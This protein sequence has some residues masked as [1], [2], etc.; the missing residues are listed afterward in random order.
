MFTLP[1]ALIVAPGALGGCSD[2]TYIAT[3][4]LPSAGAGG[5]SSGG[6]T[7]SGGMPGSGGSGAL[8]GAAGM[9]GAA[10]DGGNPGTGGSSGVCTPGQ[11]QDTGSCGQCGTKRQTCDANGQWGPEQ[12]EGQG[13]CTPGGEDLGACSDPCEAKACESNCT[14]SACKLKAGAKCSYK[15]G[16]N[17][18]C[19]GTKKWQFCSSSSCDWFPCAD[20]A[21]CSC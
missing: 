1:L 10:G 17:F 20:C 18:Q 9:A 16:T 13:V 6:A 11:K 2:D 14:W 19:C 3:N 8:A 7:S 5:T 21:S 15:S 4:E 12:C